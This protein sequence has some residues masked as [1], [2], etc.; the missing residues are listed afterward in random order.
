M[1]K[2]F[3]TNMIK[4]V[5]ILAILVVVSGYTS[6]VEHAQQIARNQPLEITRIFLQKAGEVNCLTCQRQ[7]K[8]VICLNNCENII[9][10]LERCSMEGFL[11]LFLVTWLR[12]C[13]LLAFVRDTSK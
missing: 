3:C 8:C 10:C 1:G 2:H 9:G 6:P 13:S 7:E 4:T 12:C 11:D 5:V